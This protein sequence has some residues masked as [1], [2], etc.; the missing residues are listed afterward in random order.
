M[1][2]YI[3]NSPSSTPVVYNSPGWLTIGPDLTSSNFS[4]ELYLSFFDGPDGCLL[5]H[6]EDIEARRPKTPPM[7]SRGG[8][9]GRGRGV[10]ISGGRGGG[11]PTGRGAP[12]GRTF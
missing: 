12:M 2:L 4:K 3:F 6:S 11:P 5:G 9:G 1:S 8:R 7:K 10:G